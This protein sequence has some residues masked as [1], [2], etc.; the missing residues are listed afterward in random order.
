MYKRQRLHVGQFVAILV[1]KSASTLYRP[2]S[3]LF[4]G[5]VAKPCANLYTKCSF[6][7]HDLL[8]RYQFCA[9]I[10]AATLV[11]HKRR[12]R[13]TTGSNFAL[14]WLTTRHYAIL[15]RVSLTAK[16]KTRTLY[17]TNYTC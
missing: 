17:F 9:Q 4:S 10:I 2:D 14:F 15:C 11:S 3:A 12:L 1:S 7:V 16:R 8:F 5:S 13:S 6:Y